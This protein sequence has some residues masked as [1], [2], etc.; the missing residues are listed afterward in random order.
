MLWS[1]AEINFIFSGRILR[2]L[3]RRFLFW[4][5]LILMAGSFRQK[6]ILGS[7]ITITVIAVLISVIFWIS[8]RLD[9]EV[10][11]IVTDRGIIQKHSQL[12]ESLANLR[13]IEPEVSKYKKALNALL[14]PKDELVN[15][16]KWLDGLAR[17]YQVS[18]NFSFQGEASPP[19]ENQA[20]YINFNLD[21]RGA[22]DNLVNFL[23][24]VES[25]APRYLISFDDFDFRREGDIYR[26]TL[27][28]RIFFR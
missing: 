2:R 18:E 23:K 26:I 9:E 16:S 13:T 20:G 8:A 24:D 1:G 12:I 15:F 19:S 17:A 5:I 25:Q 27:H 7:L 10:D 3:L 4:Y 22:Y 14:P 6:I 21:S 28:G 11:K